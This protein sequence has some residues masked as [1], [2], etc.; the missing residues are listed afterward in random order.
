MSG[1]E[2]EKR[3]AWQVAAMNSGTF[4]LIYII[5]SAANVRDAPYPPPPF[6]YITE[7]II[8]FFMWGAISTVLICI[9]QNSILQTVSD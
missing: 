1:E 7:G 6:V 2:K 5:A 3:P 4:S 9:S 8:Y